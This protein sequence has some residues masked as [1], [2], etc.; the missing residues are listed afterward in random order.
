MTSPVTVQSDFRLRNDD[1]SQTTATWV[2]NQN[3]NASLLSNKNYRVRFNIRETNNRAFTLDAQLEY[4]KGGAGWNA[5]NASSS[6]VRTFASANFADGDATTEQLAG[7]GTFTAGKM[8]EVDG[9]I[10]AIALQNNDTEVEFSFQIRSAD[11]ASGNTIQLRVTDA[12]TTLTTY[13]QTPTVTVLQ[14]YTVTAAQG[15]YTLSGQSVALRQDLKLVAAQGSYTLS[16][17]SVTLSK[18]F[19]FAA[20][21]GSYT[22][23][24]QAV[25]FPRTY[26]LAAGQG[27]YALSG[28]PVNLLQGRVL[29]AAQG[30]YTLSGQ[31]VNLLAGW[32]LAAAQ[33]ST[34]LA[35][36]AVALRQDLKIVAAQGSYALSGQAV[37]LLRGWKLAAAQ[38]SYV[39]AGQAVTLTYTP[40]GT[41]YTMPA[42]QGSYSLSGQ[43]VGLRQDR[44]LAAAQGSYALAGQAV[45]LTAQRLL[46]AGHGIYVLSG[47]TVGLSH[48]GF[49]TP[50]STTVSDVAAPS[51]EA[52]EAGRGSVEV[53]I[54]AAGGT[55]TISD[56][57]AP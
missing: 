36:Q 23:S 32:K 9:L 12:G 52:S 53:T 16:G 21:Q 26:V 5:V 38:G 17:Q 8:E 41:H 30:S 48:G 51:L 55:V 50:G 2:A 37:I 49:G 20:A 27:S 6:N 42:A 28:Q 54:A 34:T 33:G 57:P 35:G 39:L 44:R 4:N 1:G 47:Q 14:A 22:L 40:A 11:V 13:S 43:A 3:T 19:I 31:T 56:G 10:S 7:A 18:G 24:G 29:A 25:N 15:S 45:N 46:A